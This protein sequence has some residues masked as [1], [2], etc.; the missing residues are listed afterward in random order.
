M[1][2][3]LQATEDKFQQSVLSTEELKS[4]KGGKRWRPFRS[5]SFFHKGGDKRKRPTGQS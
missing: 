2:T 5:F 3:Q 1:I 4:L